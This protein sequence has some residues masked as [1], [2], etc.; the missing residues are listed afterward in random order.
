MDTDYGEI[1]DDELIALVETVENREAKKVSIPLQSP[2]SRFLTPIPAPRKRGRR[3][4]VPR[5]PRKR[6]AGGYNSELSAGENELRSIQHT[7]SLLRK[8]SKRAQRSLSPGSRRRRITG[9]VRSIEVEPH[10]YR[11]VAKLPPMEVVTSVQPGH[12]FTVER[13]NL[14]ILNVR[15][16]GRSVTPEWLEVHD[17]HHHFQK[18]SFLGGRYV[19]LD[20]HIK[21]EYRDL[22]E[23]IEVEDST[24]EVDF[25]D[26]E[27]DVDAKTVELVNMAKLFS[28][29]RK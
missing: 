6:K 24:D 13:Q 25:D 28:F 26:D 23:D 11:Q 8:R 22:Y 17:N 4:R 18:V 20:E 12:G 15:R 21:P 2:V 7:K 14:M 27:V 19:G 1:S 10:C 16:Q 3:P 9:V 29:T 5:A